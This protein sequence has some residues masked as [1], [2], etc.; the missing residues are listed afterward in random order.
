MPLVKRFWPLCL[1]KTRWPEKQTGVKLSDQTKAQPAETK[2]KSLLGV[3]KHPLR[4]LIIG[5]LNEEAMSAT[6]FVDR[7]HLPP[8]LFD[9][10][11]TAVSKLAYHFKEL[12]DADYLQL[13]E[14]IPRRG[15]IERVYRGTGKLCF[16]LGN[17][18]ELPFEERQKLSA[19]G[20]VA[21]AARA[22][23]AIRLGS[24]D[25]RANRHLTWQAG[26]LDLK[27]FGE[28]IEILNQASANA[29]RVFEESRIRLEQ[30]GSPE[31]C[32]IPATLSLLGYESPQVE[33]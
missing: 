19:S 16:S 4:I 26:E 25:R 21:I 6:Q 15:A 11:S 12:A 29:E 30:Q 9:T 31:G 23:R 3:V 7:G 14:S 24:F 1:L 10:R 2:H 8:G 13:I 20:F 33:Q 28:L 32:G 18:A 17:F 22:E 5:V 27:G